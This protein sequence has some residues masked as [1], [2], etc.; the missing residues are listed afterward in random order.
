M[1]LVLVEEN[2]VVIFFAER[3][4][5]AARKAGTGV[6]DKPNGKELKENYA[7]EKTP[8]FFRR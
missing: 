3:Q 4:R 5:K 8:A 6:V 2:I 7:R 1:F